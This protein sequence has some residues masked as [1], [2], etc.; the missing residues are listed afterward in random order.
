MWTGSEQPSGTETVHRVV[1]VLSRMQA[2]RF[3]GA[4]CI[5]PE[6]GRGT[7]SDKHNIK[8]NIYWSHRWE[9]LHW[10]TFLNIRFCFHATLTL[11]PCVF[12]W[13]HFF[14]TVWERVTSVLL[15]EQ[16]ACVLVAERRKGVLK[17]SS[18]NTLTRSG[19]VTVWERLGGVLKWE[20]RCSESTNNKSFSSVRVEH[21][22]RVLKPLQKS[23]LNSTHTV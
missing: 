6:A 18:Q 14:V 17:N 9:R 5:G 12:Y 16:N 3:L 21:L 1:P 22:W 13:E 7:F 11:K 4:G 23:V 8:H 2:V 10:V 19:D 15:L 20:R